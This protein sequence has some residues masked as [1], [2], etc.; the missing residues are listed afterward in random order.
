MP[1]VDAALAAF[2]GD[3]LPVN[4]QSRASMER[5]LSKATAALEGMVD[6][7]G[8]KSHT[9]ICLGCG[10]KEVIKVGGA[11]PELYVKMVT[12]LSSAAPKLKAAEGDTSAK[13]VKLIQDFSDMTSAALAEY[14]AGLEAELEAA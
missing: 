12:A 13:A 11:D 8:A 5:T 2:D 10:R 3:E 7:G 6:N 1:D 14:I 4:E 9:H